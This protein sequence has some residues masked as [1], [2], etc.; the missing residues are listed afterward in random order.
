VLCSVLGYT[1][2]QVADLL[3]VPIGTVRSRVS[4]ARATFDESLRQT[5]RDIA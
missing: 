3:D 5:Q 1:Y 2:E 4:R